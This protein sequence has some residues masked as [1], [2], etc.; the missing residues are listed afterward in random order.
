MYARTGKI[1]HPWRHVLTDPAPII[2]EGQTRERLGRWWEL[3]LD[4]GHTVRRVVCY[5][6]LGNSVGSGNVRSRSKSDV[7]PPP[8]IVRCEQCPK[9]TLG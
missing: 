2:Q 1:S 5:H 7:R 8:T 9:G 3:H 4:C 6:Q